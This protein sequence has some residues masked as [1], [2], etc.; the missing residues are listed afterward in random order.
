MLLAILR[1]TITTDKCAEIYGGERDE[2]RI[3][4]CVFSNSNVSVYN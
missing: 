1:D 4:L 3:I 2:T